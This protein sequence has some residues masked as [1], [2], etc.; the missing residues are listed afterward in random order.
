MHRRHSQINPSSP[1]VI[2][3]GGSIPSHKSPSRCPELGPSVRLSGGRG[4]LSPALELRTLG[5][6]VGG[7]R[8]RLLGAVEA[9]SAACFGMV[10]PKTESS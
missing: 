7:V 10:Y 1:M 6:G 5:G 9:V 8:V 4:A 2:G 3:P